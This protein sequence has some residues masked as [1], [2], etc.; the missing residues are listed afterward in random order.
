MRARILTGLLAA[1]LLVATGTA[2]AED[3]E[4]AKEHFFKAKELYDEGAL[5]KAIIE[6]KKSYEYSA[7]PLVSYNIGVC[8]DELHKYADALFYYSRYV[9]EVADLPP[10]KKAAIEERI[11][12]IKKF[13]GS[14][15]LKVDVE[16]AEV[17]IDGKLVGQTPQGFVSLETGE[18]DLLLRKVGMSDVK[19]KFT[20]TSGEVTTIDV[21]MPTL[22]PAPALAPATPPTT[23]PAQEPAEEEEEPAAEPGKKIGATPFWVA[24]GVTGATL[25]AITA[26]G[27]L[28]LKAESDFE[29]Q[30]REDE[31][32]WKPLQRKANN[33]ALTTDILI[34]VAAAAAA[35][36]AVL[37]VFTDFKGE[38]ASKVSL[39]PT[40]TPG[41]AG[42]V[43]TGTY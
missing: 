6:F 4:K 29:E 35:T 18:H 25:V 37:A 2:H 3:P 22:Q 9:E 8:Y 34:G 5:A 27:S 40:V 26:T 21:Q 23:P 28:A 7:V 15:E 39:G 1:G 12:K 16:G 30:Y 14:L 13:I 17:I 24:L 19:K 20:I 10:D 42:I 43:V 11:E 36:T 38:K 41:G 31:D 32:Q 33:L